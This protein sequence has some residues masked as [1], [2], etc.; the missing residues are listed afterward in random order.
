MSTFIFLDLPSYSEFIPL[1]C[2]CNHTLFM[3][4]TL[5][6]FDFLSFQQNKWVKIKGT[7]LIIC[8]S[9]EVSLSI[10]ISPRHTMY[11]YLSY[12]ST[13]PQ[14]DAEALVF[15][16]SQESVLYIHSVFLDLIIL[17]NFFNFPQILIIFTK[18]Y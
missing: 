16:S 5:A 9:S 10:L 8:L 4:G 13:C 17:N 2:G 3:C 11:I 12:L 1:F 14:Y 6:V 18:K 7:S 15:C